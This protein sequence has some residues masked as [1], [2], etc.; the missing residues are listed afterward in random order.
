MELA[1]LKSLSVIDAPV[2]DQVLASV[3]KGNTLHALVLTTG[4][5]RNR[6]TKP[7]EV[8][9][10]RLWG[11]AVTDA[12]IKELTPLTNL[13]ELT[14]DGTAITGPSFKELG[15]TGRARS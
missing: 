5:G 1:P 9:S 2:T 8:V 6:P 14:L 13:R 15:V 3:S 10:L 11:Q 7:D 4:T 12:G